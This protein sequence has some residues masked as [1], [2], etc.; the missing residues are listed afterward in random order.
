[1]KIT[2]ISVGKIKES[3]FTEA[4]GEYSKRLS[5]YCTLEIL[6]VPDEKTPDNAGE[7]LC[8]QILKKEGKRLMKH[9]REEAFVAALAIDGKP[10]T[11][12]ALADKIG[13]LGISGTSHIQFLIGGSLGLA[14]EVLSKADFRLSF[15]AMTFPHQLMRVILLEQ[16]YRSFRIL[17]GEPYHK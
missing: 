6:Q 13:S 12:E 7:A 14:P 8:R 2:V 15:S 10:L 5:R 11:S 3:Y 16:L 1:M 9:I 4:I 17:H